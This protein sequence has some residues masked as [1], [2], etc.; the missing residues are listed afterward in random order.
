MSKINTELLLNLSQNYTFNM[1]EDDLI[2]SLRRLK[3]IFNL[4]NFEPNNFFEDD[5]ILNFL[6]HKYSVSTVIQTI[7]TILILSQ[8]YGSFDLQTVY[9]EHLE[10]VIDMKTNADLYSK[11]NI[12]DIE[13]FIDKNYLTFIKGDICFSKFRHFT[14]LTLLIKEIPLKYQTLTNI[15]YV[16]HCWVDKNECLSHPVYLIKKKRFVYFYIQ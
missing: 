14:L 3:R 9:S 2:L 13:L 8:Y 10:S 4:D 6:L 7:Q 5:E 1:S 11:A 12:S 16:Y 15:K